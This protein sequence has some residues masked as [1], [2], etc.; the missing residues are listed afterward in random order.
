MERA[1]DT[2]KAADARNVDNAQPSVT[3]AR[4]CSGRLSTD[5][6]IPATGLEGGFVFV[7]ILAIIAEIAQQIATN[8]AELASQGGGKSQ[9]A[10]TP[11]PIATPMNILR[12]IICLGLTFKV[13]GCRSAQRVGSPVDCSVSKFSYSNVRNDQVFSPQV[14]PRRPK[15]MRTLRRPISV[16]RKLCQ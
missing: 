11:A 12:R 14:Q 7:S 16:R 6:A 3:L 1:S 2:R 9:T 10:A 4:G 5:K 15:K 8:L 13:T